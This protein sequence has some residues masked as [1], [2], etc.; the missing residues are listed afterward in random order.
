MLR[1]AL[2]I[3]GALNA[4]VPVAAV[5][6]CKQVATCL[7]AIAQGVHTKSRA[8]ISRRSASQQLQQAGSAA[9]AAAAAVLGGRRS[10]GTSPFS[11]F[12]CMSDALLSPR[13]AGLDAEGSGTWVDDLLGSMARAG[14][15]LLQAAVLGIT[16]RPAS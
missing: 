8:W 1:Q 9:A 13:A 16:W 3:R 10:P 11:A 6:A 12:S 2:S 7:A 4:S 14:V 15:L 5:H